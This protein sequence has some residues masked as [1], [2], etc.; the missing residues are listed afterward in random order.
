L[1]YLE[2]SVPAFEENNFQ[3]DLNNDFDILNK[4]SIEILAL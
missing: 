3:V 2:W 4:I 1:T